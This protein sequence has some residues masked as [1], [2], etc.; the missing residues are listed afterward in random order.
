VNRIT[1]GPAALN[2]FS[3]VHMG[4]GKKQT[5]N[6]WNVCT[7]RTTAALLYIY[8]AHVASTLSKWETVQRS[9]NELF[10]FKRGVML[11]CKRQYRGRLDRFLKSKHFSF[12]FKTINQVGFNSARIAQ[13][14]REKQKILCLAPSRLNR[15]V[16]RGDFALAFFERLTNVNV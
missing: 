4:A 9:E 15:T 11:Y 12:L 8:N 6:A 14:K 2:S 1:C 16:G 13:M 3:G 10:P 5:N 7:Q